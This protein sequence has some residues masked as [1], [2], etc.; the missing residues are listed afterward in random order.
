MKGMYLKALVCAVVVCFVS[1][2]GAE[3]LLAQTTGSAVTYEPMVDFSGL[4]T[5]LVGVIG[6]L[7][8]G[9]M[10]IGLSIWV[11]K[12]AFGIIRGMGR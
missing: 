4:F 12:Y 5:T 6:P 3:S 10:G 7:V 2:I 8:A 9:A 1:A 11:A